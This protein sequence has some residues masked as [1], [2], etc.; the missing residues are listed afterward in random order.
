MNRRDFVKNSVVVA[1]GSAAFSACISQKAKI[2]NNHSI[3]VQLYTLRDAMK[4]DAKGTLQLLA[5]IG[6][7]ELELAGWKDYQ[8]YNF[9]PKEW[10]KITQDLGLKTISSHVGSGRTTPEVEGTLF[11]GWEK[12]VQAAAEAGIPYIVCPN[13]NGQERKNLDDYK[14]T[15][16]F[17]NKCGELS[18]KYGVKLGYHN[19][20]FEF[21]KME[22][23][24]PYDILLQETD[25]DKVCFELDLYW[26]KKA[27]YDFKD[28]FQRFA[29][30]FEL[31]HVKDMD[32]TAEA[33]FTEVGNGIMDFKAIFAM[34]KTAGMKHFFVEQ[35]K[36]KNNPPTESVKISYNNLKKLLNS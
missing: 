16:D 35:D 1:L 7:K 30:R 18:K 12:T 21:E 5:N 36:C 24:V 29:G 32:N 8:F 11:N 28:Y 22:G 27:G 2:T 33:F 10:K 9:S 17:L 20:A 13:L 25:K 34:Q 14:K 6:Y 31:W 23:K 19:H 3:G 26:I 4:E 15:A